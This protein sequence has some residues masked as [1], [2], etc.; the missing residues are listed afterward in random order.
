MQTANY[1]CRLTN[2]FCR[3]K[4]MARPFQR[5]GRPGF[6]I[7]EV[8]VT[9]LLLAVCL[10]AFAQ[11]RS[12]LVAQQQRMS[13]MYIARS[14]LQNVFEIL[15]DIPAEAFLSGDFSR[16]NVDKLV[17]NSLPE[18]KLEFEIL[19]L[20][21]QQKKDVQEIEISQNESP[22]QIDPSVNLSNESS[23]SAEKPILLEEP[24]H[25]DEI[26][27]LSNLDSLSNSGKT[28]DNNDSLPDQSEESANSN[29]QKNEN[30]S[31]S[32]TVHLLKATISWNDGVARPRRSL[33][34]VRILP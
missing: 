4:Q 13:S 27:N 10:T 2:R 17:A 30:L 16:E 34:L 32:V 15:G 5:L 18:G 9:V 21:F 11:L 6:T 7:I 1:F 28:A 12:V 3:D 29:G 14:Q 24:V 19:P 20:V 8:A 22:N 25:P 31:D 33:S 26:E 23:Q